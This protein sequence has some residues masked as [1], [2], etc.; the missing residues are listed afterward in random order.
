M[1]H[2]HPRATARLITG[3]DLLAMGDIGACEL[4]DGRIVPMTPT[5]SEH[6]AI[7]LRLGAALSTYV[8][9]RRL[10]WVLGGE[11]GIYTKRSPDR[12]RGADIAVISKARLPDGPGKRFLEVAPELVVEIL[13]PDDRW[14]DVRQKID[15]YFMIGVDRVWVVEPDNRCALVFASPTDSRKLTD[16]DELRGEG[17]LHGFSLGVAQLFAD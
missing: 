5:G 3:D 10:G 8:R 2:T 7:E 16:A 9:A 12:V 14:Q 15:E 17:L 1:S 11:V 4:V 6:G 13:S